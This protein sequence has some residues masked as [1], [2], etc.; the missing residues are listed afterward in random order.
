MYTFSYLKDTGQFQGVDE[1]YDQQDGYWIYQQLSQI[2]HNSLRAEKVHLRRRAQHIIGWNPA[3]EHGD[4][5]R[6]HG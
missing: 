5:H 4:G 3:H 6:Q 2:V 1:R